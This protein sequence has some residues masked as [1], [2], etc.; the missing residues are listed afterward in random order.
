MPSASACVYAVGFASDFTNTILEMVE[1]L[2]TVVFLV[3]LT[4]DDK[5]PTDWEAV[6]ILK[7]RAD[8]IVVMPY[9]ERG[10]RLSL[11]LRKPS[12]GNR[13]VIA[14]VGKTYVKCSYLRAVTLPLHDES[15]SE[16][17]EED[18]KRYCKIKTGPK[19]AEKKLKTFPQRPQIAEHKCMHCNKNM[20]DL[21]L[22]SLHAFATHEKSCAEKRERLALSICA[23]ANR[24][25]EKRRPALRISAEA[26]RIPK[27]D[28]LA[29]KHPHPKDARIRFVDGVVDGERLH[30]YYVDYKC[31]GSF[32]KLD[33]LPTSSFY[34]Q[35]FSE[36]DPVKTIETMRS[37]ESWCRSKYYGMTDD[38]ILKQWEDKRVEA[39]EAGTKLHDTI[40]CHYNGHEIS[41]EMCMNDHCLKLFKSFAKNHAHLKPFRTEWRI[42]S[43]DKYKVCGSV[44]MLFIS[45]NNDPTSGVLRLKMFDWKRTERIKNF[46]FGKRGTGIL[47]NLDDTSETKYFLQQNIYKFIIENFYAPITVDG[48]TYD[49]ISVDRM[50][51]VTMHPKK[52]RYGKI[53]VAKMQSKVKRMFESRE[54]QLRSKLLQSAE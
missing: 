25:D 8:H 24:A 51:L 34:K 3:V 17:K 21:K 41:E 26:N 5:G 29:K 47:S 38:E 6:S 19:P 53:L 39:A 18:M 20:A 12:D 9:A 22:P 42:F 31:N 45:E 40:E 33:M 49:K 50:Y 11:L 37:K 27:S 46:S 54:R 44:D 32:E 30:D 10:F 4:R 13:D 35:Y 16:K 48:V 23:E 14:N 43:P 52:K 1:A 15:E 2:G 28:F 36:F 7:A